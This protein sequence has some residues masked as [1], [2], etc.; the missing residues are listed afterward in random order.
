MQLITKGILNSKYEG[1]ELENED[2]VVIIEKKKKNNI[3]RNSYDPILD[4]KIIKSLLLWTWYDASIN[5][6]GTSIVLVK[7]NIRKNSD[8]SNNLAQREAIQLI[9]FTF[10]CCLNPLPR[11]LLSILWIINS[12]DIL[13]LFLI[14]IGNGWQVSISSCLC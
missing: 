8:L 9:C 7:Q 3:N 2:F 1:Y 5:Y 11:F 12:G 14:V 10:S 4:N 13:L 6:Q